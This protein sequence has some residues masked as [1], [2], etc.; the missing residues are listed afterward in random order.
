MEVL[1]MLKIKNQQASRLTK[2]GGRGSIKDNLWISSLSNWGN[3]SIEMENWEE[4]FRGRR[5]QFDTC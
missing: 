5:S 3:D 1:G 4:S 2:G